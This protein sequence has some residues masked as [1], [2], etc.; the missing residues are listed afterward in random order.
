MSSISAFIWNFG[1]RV[2][3][4]VL[5]G[6]FVVFIVGLV[7]HFL[8]EDARKTSSGTEAGPDPSAA[9]AQPSGPVAAA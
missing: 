7:A 6:C 4:F 5:F 2:V 8:F 3:T 1:I 9:P